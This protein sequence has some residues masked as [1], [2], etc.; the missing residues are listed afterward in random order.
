MERYIW[1]AVEG[2]SV[3]EVIARVLAPMGYERDPSWVST[4]HLLHMR[5]ACFTHGAWT[6]IFMNG[7]KRGLGELPFANVVCLT[8]SD[9]DWSE[10]TVYAHGRE[11]WSIHGAL[12]DDMLR[13]NGE[14]PAELAHYFA[15][16]AAGGDDRAEVAI[17][18]ARNLTGFSIEDS[19]P[20]T[21]RIV[22]LSML[23]FRPTLPAR[24]KV[25]ELAQ[26]RAAEADR[27]VVDIATTDDG[28]PPSIA[29]IARRGA[30]VLAKT[31]DQQASARRQ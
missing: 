24:G 12:D 27:I 30:R 29:S 11:S 7:R 28:W 8:S 1:A 2:A 31:L 9:D 14:L 15:E 18:I 22:G 13:G 10:L 26:P 21:I 4:D 23:P 16:D 3:D 5:C 19:L 25:L 20:D 6:F 17:E